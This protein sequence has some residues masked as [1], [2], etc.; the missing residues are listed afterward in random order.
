MTNSLAALRTIFC[1]VLLSI[2]TTSHGQYNTEWP[3]MANTDITTLKDFDGA[4]VGFRGLYI[5]MGKEEAIA[6]LNSF[7][8]FTW[9]IDAFNTK[10]VSPTSNAQMRIYAHLRDTRGV[11]DP[12]VLYLQWEEGKPGM[13]AMV[14]YKAIAPSLAGKSARLFTPAALDAGCECRAFLHSEPKHS[15]DN[16]GINIYDFHDQHFQLISMSS[17]GSDDD[18]WFKFIQ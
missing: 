5:G 14:F 7:K 4:H 10:S 6:K 13:Y 2:A 11:D 18:V 16:I 12:A 17:L 3:D 9:K 15:K 8:D 1:V